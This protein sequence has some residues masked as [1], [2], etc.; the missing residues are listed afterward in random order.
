MVHTSHIYIYIHKKRIF[1][2]IHQKGCFE[3]KHDATMP[4]FRFSARANLKRRFSVA[5]GGRA[6]RG[7]PSDHA[8]GRVGGGS[9]GG[10]GAMPAMPLGLSG[11]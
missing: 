8:T 1:V 2:Y 10:G 9:C 5:S 7:G 4:G 3:T 11:G 6:A